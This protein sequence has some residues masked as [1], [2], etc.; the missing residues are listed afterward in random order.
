M[1]KSSFRKRGTTPFYFSFIV[2]Q[3]G[4]YVHNIIDSIFT[5]VRYTIVGSNIPILT[6]I[7]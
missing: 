2:W 4:I 1:K 3:Q 5:G 7:V 6:K